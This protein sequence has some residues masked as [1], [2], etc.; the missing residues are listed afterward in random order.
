MK[1]KKMI[2]LPR[3]NNCSGDLSKKWF[4]YYSV[5]NPKKRF[6]FGKEG[7]PVHNTLA[8]TIYGIDLMPSE[9]YNMLWIIILFL[10]TCRC[11]GGKFFRS[12]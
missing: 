1:R 7:L 5:R 4:V 10:E 11:S 6:V 3:L 2:I 9:R 8:K 12:S